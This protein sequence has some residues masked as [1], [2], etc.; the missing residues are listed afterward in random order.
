MKSELFTDSYCIFIDSSDI[1]SY[2]NIIERYKENGVRVIKGDF[3]KSPLCIVIPNTLNASKIEKELFDQE[4]KQGFW[5]QRGI[6]YAG[7]SWKEITKYEK[8]EC[9]AKAY[10]I[11]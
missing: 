8:D 1:F 5:G 3:E 6:G 7:K 9:I 4:H 10:S 11:S 2:K